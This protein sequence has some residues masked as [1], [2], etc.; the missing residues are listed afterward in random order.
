VL[1]TWAMLLT[2][3]IA[4]QAMG[5]QLLCVCGHC[6]TSLALGVHA[7]ESGEGDHSCCAGALDDQAAAQG[8][9]QLSD[10]APCCGDEHQLHNQ[11]ANIHEA[12]KAC[13]GPLLVATAL[14]T[15]AWM[16]QRRF[17]Q[18]ELAGLRGARGPPDAPPPKLILSL[19]HL[20]I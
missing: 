9:G 20:L 4:I 17:A 10:G 8:I 14:D 11:D 16:A 19:Q 2:A 12:D 15:G 5:L 13:T 7:Q 18:G 3:L 6:P 1:K